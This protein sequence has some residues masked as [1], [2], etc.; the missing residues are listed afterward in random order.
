MNRKSK[1]TIIGAGPAGLFCAYQLIKNHIPVEIFEATSG[2]CKKFLIAGSSGLNLTHSEEVAKFKLRYGKDSEL[3]EKYLQD[4][5]PKDLQEWC[6][7]LGVETFIGTSGRV[8]PTKMSAAGMLK[9]WKNEIIE[10]GLCKIHSSH[11]FLGFKDP[12]TLIIEN[13][14]AKK[15][16]EI[17]TL[18]FA[19]GGGSWK[20]TGSDGSWIKA[21]QSLDVETKEFLPMNCGFQRS[22][23]PEFQDKVDNSP[24]KN[25]V[26]KFES[27]EVRSECMLT[28]YGIEGTGI[29]AISNYIRD[30][31]IKNDQATISLDLRPDTST[32]QLIERLSRPRGKNSLSNFLRKVIKL[33]QVEST[34]LRELLSKE[35]FND[36]TTLAHKIKNLEIIVESTR[37][38]DEA[39]STSGG[40]LMSEVSEDLQLLKHPHIYL[41]GE[42]LDWD[43]PTGGYLLQGC[44]STAF[45]V[46]K[47]IITKSN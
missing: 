47:T 20:S 41:C 26:I 38:T 18:I 42:M 7:T 5:S 32:Q 19:T 21:F 44:F 29:Y 23:S 34:L 4:F 2:Q 33:N 25:V 10:S 8:F 3:F 11:K 35:E 12:K 27:H 17:E 1:V 13:N 31:I 36:M 30:E 16:I 40:V 46:A 14:S 39:I 9:T 22:W 37:P 6:K 15:E 28:P 24:L 43:A 45:R